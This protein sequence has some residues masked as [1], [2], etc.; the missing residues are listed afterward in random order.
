[1]LAKVS[2]VTFEILRLRSTDSVT[3]SNYIS[4]GHTNVLFSSGIEFFI[5]FVAVR[6]N[7]IFFRVPFKL[8]V[9]QFKRSV[10]NKTYDFLP[11]TSFISSTTQPA[12]PNFS[13]INRTYL[14]STEIVRFFSGS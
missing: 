13:V 3:K 7:S 9:L 1:M 4:L 10:H 11:P 14:I 5:S 12:L 8:K 2:N 6:A